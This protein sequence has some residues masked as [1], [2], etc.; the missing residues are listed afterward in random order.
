[1]SHMEKIPKILLENPGL[2]QYSTSYESLIKLYWNST[3]L[4][5]FNIVYKP[6]LRLFEQ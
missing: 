2:N 3:H 1:M 4:Q 6:V 5:C